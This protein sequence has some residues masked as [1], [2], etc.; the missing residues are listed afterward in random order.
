M[1]A[2][3]VSTVGFPEPPPVTSRNSS[4]ISRDPHPIGGRTFH[5]LQMDM[6][7]YSIGVR[8]RFNV[9]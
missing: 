2:I 9:M 3:M 8:L 4:P 1:R 7:L 6:Y 5:P